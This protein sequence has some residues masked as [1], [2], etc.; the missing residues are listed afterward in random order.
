MIEQLVPKRRS[1]SLIVLCTLTM[2]GNALLI[3]KELVTYYW[4]D[5][6]S[7]DRRPDAI[8][9]IDVFFLV[10]LLTC[11]GSMV[12]AMI[13]LTGKITG[14]VVYQVSSIV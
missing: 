5:S 14:L 11:L 4:L 3:L 8:L 13:M 9:L 10:E 2:L 1:V 12:G 6:T 7:D